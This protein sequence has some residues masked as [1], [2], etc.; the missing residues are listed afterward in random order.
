[1]A[2]LAIAMAGYAIGG[3]IGYGMGYMMI[4][5]TIGY[6][7][8]RYIGNTYFGPGSNVEDREGPRLQDLTV[9]VSSYGQPIPEIFGAY[10]VAGNVIWT[11]GLVE[12]SSTSSGDSG[13]KGG[14]GGGG[15]ETTYTYSVSFAVALCEGEIAGF[16]RIWL[17]SNYRSMRVKAHGP[18]IQ[19]YGKIVI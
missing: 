3:A 10:R 4:G 11:T 1:M 17:D 9:Q 13:G 8:G 2:P 5:S 7:I 18:Q 19:L 16:G 14:G 6:M 12:T 15:D